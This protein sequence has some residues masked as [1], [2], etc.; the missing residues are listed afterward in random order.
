[1]SDN[2][3]DTNPLSVVRSFFSGIHAAVNGV[4]DTPAARS[5]NNAISHAKGGYLSVLSIA[6]SDNKEAA[7]IGAGAGT[8]AAWGFTAVAAVAIGATPAGLGLALI[9]V[10]GVL[11]GYFVGEYAEKLARELGIGT[12]N[13]PY[14]GLSNSM[15][16]D[17]PDYDED[18]NWIGDG[19]DPNAAPPDPYS[20]L[21]DNMDSDDPDYDEDGNW[22]GDGPD[23]NA[24]SPDPY[25]GIGDDMDSDDPDY[26]ADGNYIG[27]D[28]NSGGGDD[29]SP[30]KPVVLDLDGD[31]VELVSLEDST[32]FYDIDGDGYR[33]RMGWVSADDGLLAYDKNGD[34]VISG[35]EELSFV[36]YVPGART[37]LEGLAHFD[38]N[39]NGKLDPGDA[40]WGRFRVWRDL[41]QD[42]ESDPG[43]LQTL[44]EAGITSIDL[45][46]DGVERT[47]AGNRVFGEGSYIDAEGTGALYDTALRYSEYG[48]REKA[49]GS[50]TVS[51][52]ESGSLYL[53]GTETGVTL[54]ATALGVIGVVGHDGADRL[55]AGGDDGKVLVGGGGDDTLEGGGGEDVLVGGEGADRLSGGGGSDVLVV[56][57]EDFA[58]GSVD[59]GAGSDVAFVEGETGVTVELSRH[60]LEAIFGGSGADSFSYAGKARV[61]MDGGGGDDTLSGGSAGDI[62]SGDAGADTL[63]GNGGN[64][65]LLGGEGSDTLEGG[66]G[67][68]V[69]QGGAGA[70]TLRGGADN[71]VYVFG[72]GD[73]RDEIEDRVVVNGTQREG[74]T[75]DVLF[76]SGALGI[77]DIMLRLSG[78]ALKIAFKDPD[79]PN[80]AFD[81]LADRV[82]IRN[83]TEDQS[84]IETLVFG[85]GSRLDLKEVVSAWGVTE[86]VAAVDLVGAMNAA[87]G[88]TLPAG[89]NAYLGGTGQD[90]L[91]GGEGDDVLRGHGENDVLHGKAGADTLEGGAGDD[92]LAGGEGA[93][94]LEGGAGDDVLAGGEGA[95][96]LDGGAGEDTAWYG[97][98]SSG[99]TA[100]L[101]DAS[102]NTG[103]ASGDTY[104]SIEN[105]Y[106]SGFDDVLTGDAGANRIHGGAG[107][108]V[109]EGGAGRDRLDGGAGEDTLSYAGSDAGVY[110]GLL[111]RRVWGGDASGDTIS[112]FEHV[113]GSAHGD[114]L[115]GDEGANR[116]S[117]GAGNDRLYGFGGDDTLEGGA[118][119]DT[120]DGDSGED[121]ASYAG[122]GAGVNVSLATGRGQGGDA[123][124]DRLVEI[125]HLVGS[126]FDDTLTGDARGNRLAGGAGAD[127]LSGGAGDDVLEGGVGADRLDGGAGEDTLSYAGS[128]AGVNV[129]LATGA[130][131]G[132]DAEG[133]TISGFEHVVGSAYGDTLVGDDGA[134]R[135]SGGAGSDTLFG[136]GGDDHLFGGAGADTL[137]GGA[138]DDVLEGGAGADTLDGSSGEDT[139]SYAGSDAGVDVSLVTGDGEGGD[140]EG[141]RLNG[142]EHLVGSG[143]DDTLTGDARGNRLAGGAGAD[144]LSGG[145]GDD[146]LNGG[147]GA[148]LLD[149]GAGEDTLSYAGSDAGVNVILST[150]R[151]WGGDAEGDT[152]SNFEHVLGSAHG[153]RLAGDAG[154]NRLS[155]GAGVDRLY[156]YGGDDHLFGGT[157]VDWLY[158]GSGDDVL[159]GGAGAD[160]LSGGAGA[161]T[162]VGSIGSDVLT[163]GAGEDMFRFASGDGADT[164]ADFTDG[165]DR[166]DLEAYDLAGGFAGL[167]LR[168]SGQDVVVEL[169]GGD[170]IT[171][172]GVGLSTLDA[173]DFL[174]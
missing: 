119:A 81:T 140:A 107:D 5:V 20:G 58:T 109:V 79:D 170:R 129:N 86:G 36:D 137:S 1:M 63:R 126:G 29:P 40:E 123:E 116:L 18:G 50:L 72:R 11:L 24:P 41:D 141:D 28:G 48:I 7:T 173:T 139:A 33:E 49:D 85:D 39:G 60:G 16:S 169:G 8:L 110:V 37:D 156:G 95:D 138:G 152:I 73:G 17:D 23:P 161:D 51:L 66:A 21:S 163:G 87:Y 26:D 104:A 27:D 93:D 111:T 106:G 162:L 121:T 43:E 77:A 143:F 70:D 62:L 127:T 133:D 57:A 3:V 102:A 9:G 4:L 149:G 100:S 69:L 84:K 42:G 103:E 75:G 80:A 59:G 34:G 78:G 157:G 92:V 124:G 118:G 15:D 91:V 74:G 130:V 10:G 55:V 76:L 89:G 38:T 52:G 35:R 53:T 171:L 12:D 128:D 82:T 65:L 147:A 148:D 2:K 125:E 32:A 142:I 44:A 45:T 122:S 64:D 31:G 174:F 166:I 120:V 71:D 114:T 151:V 131:S 158:G 113:L 25:S 135:L 105:L 98:A 172:T 112:N 67:D 61:V 54:D 88:G 99:V 154:A 19:P 164:I 13:D 155:G 136:E 56:D 115:A 167:N 46:S 96:S 165:E 97:G 90:V 83:W 47:V 6:I 134:N 94:S 132:G 22:I 150:R 14:G 168:Q 101:S 159:D 144:T 146:V 117:G 30:G 160:T 153:D 68:D 108:D 145:A